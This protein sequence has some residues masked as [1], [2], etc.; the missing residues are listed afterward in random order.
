[1][2]RIDPSDGSAT[3]DLLGTRGALAFFAAQ[4]MAGPGD[5]CPSP[6]HPGK[7]ATQVK[8]DNVVHSPEGNGQLSPSFRWDGCELALRVVAAAA[9]AVTPSLQL[10][11]DASFSSVPA[12]LKDKA[13]SV[14]PILQLLPSTQCL[15]ALVAPPLR[16]APA[17]MPTPL[18]PDQAQQDVSCQSQL[19][20]TVQI[21]GAWRT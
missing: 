1:M 4:G 19:T 9:L 13:P 16:G 17:L 15:L 10:S 14:L 3:G 18:R 21:A 6:R 2:D 8:M 12:W 11:Q 20:A 5:A 7:E